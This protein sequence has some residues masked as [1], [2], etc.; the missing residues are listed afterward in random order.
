[1]SIEVVNAFT[2]G[3]NI[4]YLR[5]EILKYDIPDDAKESIL[6][7]LTEDIF[8]FQNHAMVED[9]GQ[10]LRHSSNVKIELDRLNKAFINDRISFAK[11]FNMYASAYE[12]YANQMFID[13]SLQPGA[14]KHLNDPLTE[15]PIRVFRY[16]DKYDPDRSSIPRWQVHK[17]G[18][19]DHTNDEVRESYVSQIRSGSNENKVDHINNLSVDLKPKWYDI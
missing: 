16:Q 19:P 3:N 13:D 17:R 9:S 15:E 4:S 10:Y 7:T 8:D 5:D 11:N 6:D 14:Y 12:Q 18:L 2:S 1:M